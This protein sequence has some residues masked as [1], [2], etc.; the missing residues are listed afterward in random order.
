MIS[1]RA[2]ILS[3]SIFGSVYLF[4]TSLK[5]FNKHYLNFNNDKNQV[6]NFPSYFTLI[7]TTTFILSSFLL[8]YCGVK[9]INYTE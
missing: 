2:I 8:S 5:E 6:V 3:S 4:S 7:N 9:A 1:S